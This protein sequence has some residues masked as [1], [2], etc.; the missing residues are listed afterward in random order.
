MLIFQS[1]QHPIPLQHHNF[2]RIP[3]AR[4]PFDPSWPVHSLGKMDVLCPDCGA[5]HWMAEKLTKSSN[6]R[7]RFGICCFQGKIKLAQLHN[8]PPEL[9][10]LFRDQTPPAKAFWPLEGNYE[11]FSQP[12]FVTALLLIPCV[13]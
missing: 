4:R 6:T 3:A 2:V 10:A 12:Y 1:N 11:T 8:L 5:L 7:P 13:Y 9:N